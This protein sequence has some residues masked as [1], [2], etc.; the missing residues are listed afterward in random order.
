MHSVEAFLKKREGLS[1]QLI[2]VEVELESGQKVMAL[3]SI[4]QSKKASYIKNT[5]LNAL[6]DSAKKTSGKK[7]NCL[8][9]I[10]NIHKKCEELEIQD[11]YVQKMYKLINYD[12]SNPEEV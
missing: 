6:I 4:N 10:Q 2:E 8:D 1:F 3:T 12:V 7:G 5:E 11:E 9:Y